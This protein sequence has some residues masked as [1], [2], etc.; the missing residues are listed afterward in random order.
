VE[1][2][3]EFSAASVAGFSASRFLHGGDSRG[4][5]GS[6]TTGSGRAKASRHGGYKDKDKDH[7]R[8]GHRKWG[9]GGVSQRGPKIEIRSDDDDFYDG[10]KWKAASARSRSTPQVVIREFLATAWRVAWMVVLFWVYLTYN[11]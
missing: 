1:D 8:S 6:T 11:G 9:W 2:Y 4:R 7:H 10:G 5:S 3:D